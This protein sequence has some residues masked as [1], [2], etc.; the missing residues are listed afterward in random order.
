MAQEVR[1]TLGGRVLD[2]QGAMVPNATVTV[3]SDETGVQ[4][5]TRSNSQGNWVVE[6]LLPGHYHFTVAADGFK[7]TEQN[8]IELQAADSKQIDVQ[9]QVGSASQSVVVTAE[10]PLID[11]T[12]ATSGTVITSEE[13]LE[14]PSSSW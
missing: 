2:A 1:A 14:M 4:Q 12:S 11:S 3:V 8:A 9:L 10:A 5:R 7:T 6:F 13:I